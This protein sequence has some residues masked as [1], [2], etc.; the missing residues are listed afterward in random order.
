MKVIDISQ[1]Q[2]AVDFSK[3]KNDGVD[4]IILRLGWISNKNNHKLDSRFIEYYNACKNL[5]IPI[6]VYLY[7][8]AATEEKVIDGANWTVKQLQGKKLELPVYIDME[9]KSISGLGKERLTN[10]CTAFNNIIEKAGYWA[11]VYAN[12][13]WYNNYLNKDYI[14]QR[15]TTWIAHYGVSTEKYKGQYDMLQY[16]SQGKVNGINGNVDLDILYRDLI[17]EING[18][19]KED[20]T[21]VKKSNEEIANE[22]INGLWGNGDNR[23][24]KL[25]AAGYDYDAIQNIVNNKLNQN[26][27]VTYTVK[28]GDTLSKIAKKY[29]T[30]VDNLVK[31]NNIKDKN[32]IYVGQ[33][34]KI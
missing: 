3:V 33:I 25:T 26:K 15:Y 19:S 32:K 23:K 16:T 21:P 28:K 17:K 7:N 13:N 29:K 4:A 20:N 34:I 9:D 10:I 8:Y 2:G 5:N 18:S 6:G 12:L 1:W 14:R 22:V 31:K 11:G 27:E 30:T 24:N